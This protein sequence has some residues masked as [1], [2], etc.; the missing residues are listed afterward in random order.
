MR[1]VTYINDSDV[2]GTCPVYSIVHNLFGAKHVF[3]VRHELD[4]ISLPPSLALLVVARLTCRD[5]I[6]LD[7]IPTIRIIAPYTTR[8]TQLE[9]RLFHVLRELAFT[10]GI[11]SECFRQHEHWRT[12]LVQHHLHK[13]D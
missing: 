6:I 13:S 3:D 5:A 10:L 7:E 12:R 9:R 1:S 11:P 2:P 4:E 8:M